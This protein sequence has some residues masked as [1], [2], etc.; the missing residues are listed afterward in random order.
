MGGGQQ[1]ASGGESAGGLGGLLSGPIPMLVLMFVIFYFLLIRPQQK[2]AKAHKAM[3]AN[4]HKG[5]KILTNGGIY[6][7]V[8]GLDDQNLTL[9]IAPQVRIKVSRGHIAGVVGAGGAP[10]APPAKK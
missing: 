4:I 10:P 1:S 6:G 9:E 2:K 3:L 7:R 8:T 5:D